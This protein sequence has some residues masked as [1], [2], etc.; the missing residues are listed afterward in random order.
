MENNVDDNTGDNIEDTGD[1]PVVEPPKKRPGRP[2]KEREVASLQIQGIIAKPIN[3]EDALELVYH[4]P[5][6]FS[7]ILKLYKNYEVKDVEMQCDATGIKFNAVDHLGKSKIHVFIDGACMD[8]Y[9]CAEP[10]RICVKRVHLE[11]AIGHIG[12]DHSRITIISKRD[13]TKTLYVIIRGN[14]YENDSQ[15]DIEVSPK[16]DAV[17]ATLD[18]DSNYPVKFNITLAHFKTKIAQAEKIG[19]TLTIEK[20]GSGP[21]QLVG[22]NGK[23]KQVQWSDIYK[24]PERMHLVSTIADDDVLRASII[25]EYIQPFAKSSIGDHVHICVH[26][27]E[28]ISLASSTKPSD[29]GWACSVKVFTDLHV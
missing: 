21:L 14:E 18:D 2:R 9:Y 23:G 19:K 10:M 5:A 8:A 7:K 15:Y 16:T 27:T 29:R 22:D 12:K 6:L 4:D 13:D 3:P 24:N 1:T 17:L 28:K 26:K 11:H 25:I 20:A